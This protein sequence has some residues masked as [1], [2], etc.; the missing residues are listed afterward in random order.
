MTAEPIVNPQATAAMEKDRAMKASFKEFHAAMSE[1]DPVKWNERYNASYEKV[2]SFGPEIIPVL[3]SSLQDTDEQVRESASILLAAIGPSSPETAQHLIPFLKDSS[4]MVRVNLVA[5][6]TLIPEQE[7]VAIEELKK[8]LQS[9][10]DSIKST[11]VACVGN[12]KKHAQ[13]LIP[14]I[15]EQLQHA[16]PAIRMLVV[17][18]LGE[19]EMEDPNIIAALE[20][21]TQSPEESAELKTAATDAL[22]QI[23]SS[24]SSLTLPTPPDLSPSN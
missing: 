7:P 18:S 9:T 4:E 11:A 20:K 23:R 1:T 6:L 17:Q 2:I 13:P 15:L 14:Q 21:I 16:S 3:I 24:N 22:S 12:L 5:C 8:L 19:M 10:D